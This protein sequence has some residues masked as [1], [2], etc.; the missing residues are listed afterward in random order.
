V[1]KPVTIPPVLS[2]DEVEQLLTAAKLLRVR[3]MLSLA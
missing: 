1:R 3:V 2:A